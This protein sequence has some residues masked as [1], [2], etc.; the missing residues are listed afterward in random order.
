MPQNS[1][2]KKAS[3]GEYIVSQARVG[4][5][6]DSLLSPYSVYCCRFYKGLP[7]LWLRQIPYTM[8]KFAAFERTVEFL[9]KNV[10]PIPRDQMSKQAQLVVTFAGGYIAGVFCALV[11]H[12]ADTVV[13]KLNSEAGSTAIQAAKDLGMKGPLLALL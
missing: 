12:P 5:T 7:P 10:V 13:S 1:T 3:Q 11:S 8:M 9:Y 4:I 6:A 2:E